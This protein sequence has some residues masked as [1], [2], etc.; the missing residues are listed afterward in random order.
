[1][2]ITNV[3][4]AILGY[5]LLLISTRLVNEGGISIMRTQP[6]SDAQE[7]IF[8]WFALSLMPFLSIAI[9]GGVLGLGNMVFAA[10]L[11]AG[12]LQLLLIYG[13]VGLAGNFRLAGNALRDLVI[14]LVCVVILIV[15]TNYT[16]SKGHPA[17]TI[18]RG[19]G[20]FLLVLAV[21]FLVWTLP[22]FMGNSHKLQRRPGTDFVPAIVFTL[23]GLAFAG[24]GGVLLMNNTAAI[25]YSLNL[26]QGVLGFAVIG[27]GLVLPE[28]VRVARKF[29]MNTQKPISI[30][31]TLATGNLG[32]LLMIGLAA[33]IS[34]ITVTFAG[35]YLLLT[36][37]AVIV[38]FGIL[39]YISNEIG[40]IKAILYLACFAL[41]F[42]GLMNFSLH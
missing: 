16:W 27:V 12:V 39:F 19:A 4:L 34:P 25:T 6:T 31:S 5:V 20:V 30:R 29:W 40:K 21:V 36:C 11:T 2:G 23:V 24:L 38:V 42:V 9:A 33:V 14:L 37:V 7:R 13:M 22:Y 26:E 28:Y 18:S 15:F 41:I 35:A 1:M 3:L 32:L 8:S 17:S 10:A